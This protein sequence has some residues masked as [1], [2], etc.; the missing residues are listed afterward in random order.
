MAVMFS[1]LAQNMLEAVRISASSAQ[2]LSYVSSRTKLYWL[3]I[4]TGLTGPFLME[5]SGGFQKVVVCLHNLMWSFGQNLDY[6]WR[7]K[8]TGVIPRASRIIKSNIRSSKI[9]PNHC[10]VVSIFS[11]STLPECCRCIPE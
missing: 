1:Q 10:P 3:F 7:R 9:F 5:I 11:A 8:M 4:N 6:L 2:G